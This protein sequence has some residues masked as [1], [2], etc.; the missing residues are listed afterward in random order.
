MRTITFDNG[1][2][3]ARHREIAIDVN[4]KSYAIRP[5]TSQDKR[6]I[7]NRIGVIKR[8]FPKKINL[9]SFLVKRIKE[10]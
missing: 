1:K 7:E 2:A 3:F 4:S 10:L 8:F 6:T 5:D 9:K